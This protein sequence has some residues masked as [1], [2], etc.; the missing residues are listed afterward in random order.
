MHTKRT[1]I[2]HDKG[3]ANENMY[4]SS[5]V[6]GFFFIIEVVVMIAIFVFQVLF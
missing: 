2:N 5:N 4:R 3:I 1:N 6:I